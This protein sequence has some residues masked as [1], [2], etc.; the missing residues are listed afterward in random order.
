[1][2]VGI[3]FVLVYV[4]IW[5]LKDPLENEIFCAWRLQLWQAL[6]CFE[7]LK[8][9]VEGEVVVVVPLLEILLN[10]VYVGQV[11]DFSSN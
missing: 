10:C 8:V 5:Y 4:Q 7:L 1:M 11:L 6:P 2:L 9:V 3:S